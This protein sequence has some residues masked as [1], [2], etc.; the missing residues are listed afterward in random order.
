M[1]RLRALSRAKAFG[2]AAL[3]CLMLLHGGG[4]LALTY[5]E[6]VRLA[7][8][9]AKPG[10]VI[11]IEEGVHEFD[12]PLTLN[13]PGVTIR[14]AGLDKTV[15][16]FRNQV[17]GADGV[18]VNAGDFL[19]EDLAIEDVPGDSLR[20]ARSENIVVRR[21]RV[22]WTDGPKA[23][24]GGYGIFPVRASNVLVED[25][26]AIGASDAGIYVGQSTNVVIRNNI[27][28]SN[29]A[30]IEVENSVKVDLYGNRA[31]S[32]VAGIEI[33]NMPYLQ[34][35]GR[36]IRVFDNDLIANNLP[37]FA[38]K[39]TVAS[40]LPA[41]AGVVIN[42]IDEIEVFGNRF[43]ENDTASVFIMS[44]FLV[45]YTGDRETVPTFDPY[46]EHIAIY[47]NSHERDGE[48]PTLSELEEL[49]QAVFAASGRLPE[50]VWDGAINPEKSVADAEICLGDED[51]GI[52]SV[53]ALNGYN[54]ITINDPAH[55][56]ALPPLTPVELSN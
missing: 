3:L 35:N 23:A 16:S 53:D 4:A 31:E 49:R 40:E 29:V 33:L 37:N 24:N 21:V 25:S 19:I 46:P 22:E 56:C 41:G 11:T 18:V 43:V 54:D 14:G 13:T 55:R 2:L 28:R 9:S 48:A 42:A 30:G 20:I 5:P 26:V 51:V 45:P 39:G 36:S 15:L 17:A 47:Q 1:M 27:V 8:E 50:V 44:H 12:R 10:D 38:T 6:S 32:N 34:L 52:V 7:F